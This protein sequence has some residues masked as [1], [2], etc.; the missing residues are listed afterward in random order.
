[1]LK[2]LAQAVAELTYKENQYER[3]SAFYWRV[4]GGMSANH[5]VLWHR[6]GEQLR[7]DAMRGE[8]F[9]MSPHAADERK[10]ELR[11]KMDELRL[12]GRA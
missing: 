1:M 3:Y 10:I 12:Q 6:I 11:Q 5:R 7:Q 8:N 9:F 2:F 4:V